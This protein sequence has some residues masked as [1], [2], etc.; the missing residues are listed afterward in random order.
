MS[1]VT[2]PSA[3]GKKTRR[4]S[5][6]PR[7][8]GADR[9]KLLQMQ[10][11]ITEAENK[12]LQ[13]GAVSPKVENGK[14]R[15]TLSF[16]LRSAD[17]SLSIKR[18]VQQLLK[19]KRYGSPV[20]E[21]TKQWIRQTED[22]EPAIIEKL[23]SVGLIES[24]NNPT[25]AEFVE[26]FIE[27]KRATRKPGTVFLCEQAG[28][29]LKLRFA[30]KRISEVSQADAKDF[31]HWLITGDSSRSKLGE[32]T[33]RRRLGR[34]REIFNEAIEYEIITRNPF[35]LKSLP[36]SVGAGKK[37]YVPAA[38]IEA[39][40]ENLPADK[41]EW[42]LLF[43][44]GRFIGCRMP[45]E[46]QG[47]IWSDVNFEANTI[48]LKSPKTE[49]KGKSERMVP[50][51]S[52]VAS[53]LLAQSHAADKLV[54]ELGREGAGDAAVYV[55]PKLRNHSNAATTAAK[56]VDAAGFASWP[57]FWNSLRA[58]RETD[59]M[60]LYGLRK[61]CAWI[62]NSPAVAIKHYSLMR[63]TDFTDAGRAAKDAARQGSQGMNEPCT[64]E[65][66]ERIQ[67]S[68]SEKTKQKRAS[69]SVSPQRGELKATPHGFERHAEFTVSAM[70][71]AM[72]AAKDA[73]SD[74]GI[75]ELIEFF[76]AAI[77][78]W[79]AEPESRAAIVEAA[80]ALVTAR[81]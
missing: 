20:P 81:V 62:G 60:D 37:E 34:A 23:R 17:D 79:Q 50:I 63:A 39:V 22:K 44:F 35:A 78:R 25:V 80:K 2:K 3:Q 11:L 26:A 18:H 10:F 73:A 59:L 38:T 47:L 1:S 70:L 41:L 55:F 48:L 54:N 5:A 33:A 30:G 36:V 45:S 61:A 77:V 64:L 53:L 71:S 43:A 24:T 15:K 65:T 66:G 21:L 31:W 52:E 8:R 72:R 74:S 9:L 27:R 14:V 58:S 4:R 32:N 46:I 19:A 56:M 12:K 7:G 16:G 42:K 51:F 68:E 13:P 6:V 75:S 57:K 76:E 67:S 69:S 49:R 28:N 40:I 29:D